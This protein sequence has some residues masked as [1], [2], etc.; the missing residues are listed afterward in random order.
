MREDEFLQRIEENIHDNLSEQ[1][2]DELIEI[3]RRQPAWVAVGKDPMVGGV[4]EAPPDWTWDL[5]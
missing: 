4:G 2:V 5:N 1:V 3:I